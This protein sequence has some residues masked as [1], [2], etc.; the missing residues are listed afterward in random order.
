MC[1][2]WEEFFSCYITSKLNAYYVPSM[3]YPVM[4]QDY[5]ICSI[6]YIFATY[7]PLT[8]CEYFCIS[9]PDYG[10]S[11]AETRSALVRH[12]MKM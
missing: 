9:K 5:K 7:L 3:V 8:S 1:Q 4:G 6:G 12:R 2:T 11:Q 10:I